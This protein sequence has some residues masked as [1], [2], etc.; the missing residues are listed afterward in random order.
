MCNALAAE[1][2]P[3]SFPSKRSSC[4]VTPEANRAFSQASGSGPFTVPSA[5][6]IAYSSN[7]KSAFDAAFAQGARLAPM[8]RQTPA[9]PDSGVGPGFMN[10]ANAGDDARN[11]ANA[12]NRFFIV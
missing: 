12:A 6:S 1:S 8:T 4:E 2:L 5:N 10:C 11:T 9:T 7:G 3:R